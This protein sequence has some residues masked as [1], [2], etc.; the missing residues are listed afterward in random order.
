MSK[1]RENTA[2][3]NMFHA[4]GTF[5]VHQKRKQIRQSWTKLV[6]ER[7]ETVVTLS[8]Q[9][10]FRVRVLSFSSVYFLINRQ[11]FLSL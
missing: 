9:I 5:L 6:G 1:T 10:S 7:V 3:N 4:F 11:S 2:L 8:N